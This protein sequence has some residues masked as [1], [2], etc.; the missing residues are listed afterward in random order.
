[1]GRA[2]LNVKGL[3]RGLGII[4]M[5][6]VAIVIIVI[7]IGKGKSH[8]NSLKVDNL[9]ITIVDSTSNGNLITTPMIKRL[10]ESEKI[11]TEGEPIAQI[12]FTR[13]ESV[14]EKNGFVERADA[15]SNY[16]GELHIE[17]HQRS[18]AMRILLN[19]Y[20]CYI[21]ADGYIFNAPPTTALYTP[22]VTGDY[23]P[24]FPASYVGSIDEYTTAEID[25]LGLDIERIEREK[26]P[27][28]QRERDNNEDKREV[29]RKFINRSAFESKDDFDRRVVALREENQKKRELYA[30]RQRVIDSELAAI[31]RRQDAIREEQ[32]KL[33]K[34]CD[35]IH[36]LI[37]FVK[38][39]ERDKFWRCEVVQIMLSKGV[40]NQIRISMA[41]RS[42]SFKVV[43]GTLLSRQEY[44]NDTEANEVAASAASSIR[45]IL[46]STT[47]SKRM[48]EEIAQRERR[49]QDELLQ[50]SINSRLARLKEFYREA[51]PRV[52]WDRYREINIEF[53]NQVV[54]QK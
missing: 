34:Y 15:Y 13:I 23:K 12:P 31:N 44:Y 30:Y 51:L 2:K 18:A 1:M 54:C 45:A 48:R 3:L 21:S 39:V 52:G 37:T 46:P 6:I 22:V 24:L 16:L 41:M 4:A 19:G 40:D 11:K 38:T 27:I 35:D 10:L 28:Y 47:T 17:I 32:K 49:R 5:W 9:L 33:Q 36:N 50:E 20:N 25:K 26:F 53:N 8:H 29:R 14:I 42:G 43:F 7:F